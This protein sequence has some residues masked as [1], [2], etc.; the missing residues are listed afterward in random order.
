MPWGSGHG[1]PADSEALVRKWHSKWI[2][3]EDLT[4][5]V[6][7]RGTGRYLGGSGLHRIDWDVPSFEI[8]YWL[9]RTAVG[10]GYMTEAAWL[11]CR[12]AFDSL[13]ASRVFL[14]CGA[15]NHRS[16]AIARRLNFVLEGTMRNDKRDT[17]GALYDMLMFGMTP[18]DYATALEQNRPF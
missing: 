1:S 8:G 3:R 13:S 12:F 4:L 17:N 14:R 16:S 10:N 9:R 11:L 2:L 18:Q 5:G 15:G 7:D 6:W